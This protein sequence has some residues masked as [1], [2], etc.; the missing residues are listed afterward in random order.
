MHQTGTYH[1]SV[2]SDQ[3]FGGSLLIGDGPSGG[4]LTGVKHG[5]LAL[6]AGVLLAIAIRGFTGWVTNRTSGG[7]APA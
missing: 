5:A 1:V 4:L 2:T 3:Q 7:V 6:V